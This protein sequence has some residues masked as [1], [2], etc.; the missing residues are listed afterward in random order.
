[1][2]VGIALGS[3]AARGWSHIGVI[4]ALEELG[5]N[6]DIIAGCSIG[7]YVGAAYSH[8]KLPAL[9]DWVQNLTEWQVI[10]LMGV[11]FQR[12]GLVSGQKVFA[13]LDQLFTAPTFDQLDKPFAAVATDLYSGKEVDFR[14]GSVVEAVRAS[15]AIPGLFPP[16][17]LNNRWLVDGAVVNP[18]PVNMCRLMGA[19]IV[20]AVNLSADF[21]PQS[22]SGNSVD[23]GNNQKKTSDFFNRSKSQIKQWFSKDNKSATNQES[24]LN[25]LTD[26]NQSLLNDACNEILD[27]VNIGSINQSENLDQPPQNVP[28]APSIINTMTGSLDILTARVTRSRLAGDPPDILIEPQLRDFGMMEF[29]RASELIAE[30]QNSVKRIAQQI[31]YQLNLDQ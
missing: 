3:G 27:P 31:Q 29:Y 8:G 16:V 9:S 11:G 5:V 20:I 13:A 30:G 22:L 1:M 25:T 18:V 4:Q 2:K 12:G 15:C 17:L 7:A 19:D 10:S 14:Q 28:P 26:M 6:I 24:N 21:R 23:H